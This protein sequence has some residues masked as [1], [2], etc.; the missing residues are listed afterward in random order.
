MTLVGKVSLQKR[1][2]AIKDA[3]PL[4]R[5]IQL[6]TVAEAK[7]AVPRK[8][9]NLGRSIVIG[10]LTK[11]SAT[12]EAKANY[13]AYVELGTKPHVILPKNRKALAWGGP[14]RLS[15]RLRAG[16]RPEHFAKKVNHPGTKA[17]PFLRPAAEKAV[18]DVTLDGIVREWNRAG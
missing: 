10:R 14:R 17:K 18:R 11:S 13:A 4:L 2:R 16:A 6:R 7:R 1:L 12:V 5:E 9:G 8:T 15:G 3:Q